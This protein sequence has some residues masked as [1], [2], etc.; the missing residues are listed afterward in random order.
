MLAVNRQL[1]TRVHGCAEGG[2]GCQ[3]SSASVWR[4]MRR[5]E[6]LKEQQDVDATEDPSLLKYQERLKQLC[7]W[8]AH[9][10]QVRQDP[11]LRG[12]EGSEF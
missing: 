8:N 4:E 9:E 3:P 6:H 11:V 5:Q 12:G 1:A 2:R 10:R 7:R